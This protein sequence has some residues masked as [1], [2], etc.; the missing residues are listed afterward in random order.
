MLGCVDHFK[1]IR[2]KIYRLEN[3]QMKTSMNVTHSHDDGGN[4][5]TF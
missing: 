2:I 1:D 4:E 3:M 5:G